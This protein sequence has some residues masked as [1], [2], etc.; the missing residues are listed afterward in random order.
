MRTDASA[1][2]LPE[3]MTTWRIERLGG[4]IRTAGTRPGDDRRVAEYRRRPR[5]GF[6][7][8][9][10]GRLASPSAEKDADRPDVRRL[11]DHRTDRVANLVESRECVHP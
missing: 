9:R 10:P 1:A 8:V 11:H 2:G 6:P 7:A 5:R 4:A 3:A